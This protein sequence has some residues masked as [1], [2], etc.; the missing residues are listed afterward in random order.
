[1]PD[2]SSRAR[3]SCLSPLLPGCLDNS[4]PSG[5]AGGP[6]LVEDQ[7]AA[8]LVAS[9]G[10][11]FSGF[12]A[13]V[14]FSGDTAV[15]GGSSDDNLGAAYIFVRNGSSWS[16]Q[17][18][19]LGPYN[20]SFGRSVAISG[21]T[22]VIGASTGAGSAYVFVRAG[23]SWSLQA[24]L[25]PAEPWP[26]ANFGHSVAI[27]GDTVIV[28]APMANFG[29]VGSLGAAYI[30]VRSGSSWSEQARLLASAGDFDRQFGVSVAI[31]GDSVIVGAHGV[32]GR[33]GAAYLFD[34]S[35]SSWSEQAKIVSPGEE[36]GDGFGASVAISGDTA[37][38]GA[39]RASDPETGWRPGAVY[40]FA[41]AGS[42]WTQQTKLLAPDGRDERWFG[43][44]VALSGDTLGVGAYGDAAYVFVRGIP[45][46]YEKAELLPSDLAGTSNSF[47]AAIA[48]S[49]DTVIVG[50]GTIISPEGERLVGAGYVFSLSFS[51]GVTVSP[52]SGLVT[53]EWG[54]TTSFFVV[55]NSQPAGDVVI[56]LASSDPGE[57]SVSPDQLFFTPEDW[58]VPQAVTLTG[59]DDFVKDDNQPYAAIVSVNADLTADPVY[60]GIDPPDPSAVNLGL[61]GE[62]YTV[63]PCRVLDT[64]AEQSPGLISGVKR[65]VTV[66]DICGVPS[67]AGAVAINVTV[68]DPTGRGSLKLS[69]GDLA[70]PSYSFLF[71]S[72][73][74]TRCGSALV[75]LA[76]DNTGTLAVW[77]SLVEGGSG[78][79]IVDISGYFE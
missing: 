76:T 8:K 63:I 77:P 11:P 44:S 28:G 26:W 51:P 67:T 79:L 21:E 31:S 59:V 9:A 29:D 2:D 37:A 66:H 34:R 24:E 1:M 33:S 25:T 30:F 15:F 17:A 36:W 32:I 10:G 57:G 35:G 43:L 49:G 13:S 22:V 48:L 73:G 46:W 18:V 4:S 41:R 42:S 39:R 64:R 7:R 50:T 55:L 60:D 19:L 52:G 40:I 74:Q 69:A 14:A 45:S 53:T 68:V 6:D 72:A 16:E 70:P 3:L 71:F 56:D 20:S 58:Y 47:G 78:H 62:L 27:E 65:L 61:E 54:G 23:S 38:V 5:S 75:P 12:G